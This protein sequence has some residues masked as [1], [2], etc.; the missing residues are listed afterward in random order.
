MLKIGTSA[1]NLVC[2]AIGAAILTLAL[3]AAPAARADGTLINAPNRV[4]IAYDDAR[5]VLYISSGAQVLRY[6]VG[7]NTFLSAVTLG[8]QLGGM[9]LSPN[10]KTLAVADFSSDSQ[11]NW[12]HLLNL[13]T[14][15]D[16][17]V[18]FTLAF[19]EGGTFTVAYG[20]DGKLLVT[21]EY[22]GS[23]WVPLRLYDPHTKI[24]ATIGTVRQDSMLRSDANRKV[25]ALAE[26]NIS[27]G[28]FGRYRVKDG[29]LNQGGETGWFNFEI[30]VNRKGRIFAIPTYGG[31][32]IADK[33]LALTG[34]VIGVY[35]S[36]QPIAAA[37]HPTQ[38]LVYFPWAESSLVE[39]Y[40]TTT[41]TEVG[42]YNFEATFPHTGNGA[43]IDG[44]AKTSADGSLLFVTVDGGV[45]YVN[46]VT[47][48]MRKPRTAAR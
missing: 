10:G 13:D 28:R 45:R 34:T 39:V 24:T 21:S 46:T 8:G 32:F 7:S 30:G 35:A 26:S 47:A 1:V 6:Q 33:N 38:D 4:D 41:W 18:K 37:F 9:D 14:L 27:D 17:K 48:P 36:G 15:K 40:D 20:H 23:G 12:V 31:T 29:D 2:S 22:V 5:D 44:R 16:K 19:G 25:V 3:V 43:F 11:N 42:S